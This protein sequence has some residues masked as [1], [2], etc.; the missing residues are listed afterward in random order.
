MSRIQSNSITKNPTDLLSGVATDSIED[1]HSFFRSDDV[2]S[3]DGA[4]LTFT[5]DII[6]HTLNKKVGGEVLSTITAGSQALS[7]NEVAFIDIDRTSSSGVAIAVVVSSSFVAQSTTTKNRII[8]AYRKNQAG[9]PRLHIPFH[10]QVLEPGQSIFF[11]ATGDIPIPIETIA[12][13]I[14]DDDDLITVPFT[15]IVNREKIQNPVND[16]KSRMGIERIMTQDIFKIQ[17][18]VG[19]IGERIFG[20]VGDRFDRIRFVGNWT[21]LFGATPGSLGR[22]LNSNTAEDFVEITF[23]GTGLNVLTHTSS[24]TREIVAKVDGGAEGS[25]LYPGITSSPTLNGRSYAPNIILPIFSGLSLGIHTV[26][27]RVTSTAPIAGIIY[28]FEILNE[29][30]LIT[31]NTGNAFIESQSTNLFSQDTQAFDTTFES[32]VLGTRGGHVLM[33]FKK[34]GTVKKAVVPTE[35]SQLNLGAADHTNEDIIRTY[36]WREFGAGRNDDFSLLENPSSDRA[37]VLDDGTTSMRGKNL[38]AISSF[39]LGFV[40][41]ASFIAITFVGTGLDIQDTSTAPASTTLGDI[42]VDGTNVGT[43]VTGTK[44]G[45]IKIVSGLP[46]GTHTVLIDNTVFAAT[47]TVFTDFV[48]YGPKKPALP[49]GAIEIT[50][51][52]ILADFVANTTASAQDISTG[53]LRKSISTREAIYKD[54][55]G[56]S[57]SWTIV[58]DVLGVS[59]FAQR[60]DRTNSI[61]EYTFF[62]TGFDFRFPAD[63]NFSSNIVV[64]IDGL[65]FD[66]TNFPAQAAAATVYGT[67]VVFTAATGSLDQDNGGPL[68]R[69]AGFVVTGLALSAHTIK[70]D[71]NSGNL[72]VSTLDIITPIHF[73]TLTRST[74]FQTTQPVGSTALSDLRNFNRFGDSLTDVPNI[75]RVTREATNLY[76]TTSTDLVT[77]QDMQINFKMDKPG[78]VEIHFESS[79]ELSAIAVDSV[80]AIIVNGVFLKERF[81][82]SPQANG[83]YMMVLSAIKHFSAGNHFISVQFKTASDTL[84]SYTRTL[85]VKE[86]K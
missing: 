38:S 22:F 75:A 14:I 43:Y 78:P 84:R 66:T 20:V 65:V 52:Y 79:F 67:G 80:A 82:K 71:N 25:N 10:K 6:F 2:I 76:S 68:V 59:G 55:T 15:E 13:H 61:M 53:V 44:Q 40:D 5:A 42:F 35:A 29:S 9:I 3:W 83:Q 64:S 81:I 57:L 19:P 33:Y 32:G 27:I 56:G 73:P 46:Y 85:T 11:G 62:G 60:S 77:L 39:S 49:S 17:G 34:D 16:L 50:N 18:E 23:Y 8:L 31:T 1:R 4:T 47:T 24:D 36:H 74:S 51:Y 45:F 7:D 41:G 48:I 63:L 37:F 69:G 58:L 28:G 30:A 54:G 12:D 26:K 86:I 72:H 21:A 70:F